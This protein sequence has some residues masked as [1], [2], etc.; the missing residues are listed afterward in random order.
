MILR[1]QRRMALYAPVL[2]ATASMSLL[3][4]SAALA[5]NPS[6]TISVDALANRHLINP[7][8]YGTAYASPADIEALNLPLNRMGGNNTS[9]Y[10][11]NLNADN[12]G[13][14]WYYQSIGDSNATPGERTDSFMTDT[15]SKGAQPMLTI[16]MI[17]Y[18]AK[19]GPNRSKLSSFSISKYGSQTDSDWQ[20]FPDA[21]NGISTAP[22]NP[23]I[24]G[25]NP[26]DAN[27]A[28][29]TSFMQ[30]WV[31]H[32]VSVHGSAATSTGLKY[33]ILDNEPSIWHATHRD[34]HP[35]GASMDEVRDKM[36]AYGE[37]IK[38]VDPNALTV[39]PEEWGWSGYFYSGLDLQKGPS[40]GWQNLPDR[41]AHGNMDYMPYI[42]DQMRR[43]HALTGR[44]VLDVFTV[45]IYPQ[46]GEYSN[47]TSTTM[48]QLRNRSTR[49]LWDPNY[50]DE[51]WINDK[52]MLI[53]RLQNWV[54]TYYPGT[55]IGITEYNWGAE[56]HINGATTQADIWGIFGR[57]NLDMATFWTIPAAN[58]PTYQA[59]KI[60]RNYDGNK[61]TFGDTSVSASAPSPDNV[62]AFAAVR[63]SDR[64]L[65][66]MVVAKTLSGNTPVNVSL[67][68]FGAG[69]SAQVWQL[70]RSAPTTI[71]RLGDAAVSSNTVALTVPPQS[72]T[73]LVIPEASPA[74]ATT[75]ITIPV[76]LQSYVGNKTAV[77][78]TVQ[79]RQPGST[80]ELQSWTA[81]VSASGVLTV[82]TTRQGTFD[83]AIKGPTFLRK[84]IRNISVGA[85]GASLSAITLLNGDV[86]G[87]NKVNSVDTSLIKNA[88]GSTPGNAKW[89]PAADLNG[90]GAVNST[91]RS[92]A[93]TNNR[94]NGDL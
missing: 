88:M 75:N 52:V 39:G 57:E 53:P 70:N 76:T 83:L 80:T 19:L 51:S 17:G 61:G 29:S 40:L 21:G 18:V 25:N 60:Y 74:T 28:S 34:V 1:H 67:A 71:S 47:D 31:Q 32:L 14:D 73:L 49:S 78:L 12:K 92:I 55:K 15:R 4:Q 43:R 16:P 58:T 77:P 27:V 20:W 9:R 42:L 64:A 36:I 22:G 45:H 2:F 91:D 8:I 79:L 35:E 33:Y 46:S 5:Q 94:K 69:T 89:N 87:N 81:S 30:S 6:I 62:S 10:N 26:L 3:T 54:K 38:S 85:S 65:T 50:T 63:S 90:S 13:N 72:V 66:V 44:R 7:L 23:F 41:T 68:N 48:Q 84:T 93:V 24:T 82:S 56:G 86:N 37:M 59:M 11:W